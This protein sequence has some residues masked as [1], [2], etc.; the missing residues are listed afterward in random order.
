M[1]TAERQA[2]VGKDGQRPTLPGDGAR[3]G[4]SLLQVLKNTGVC[5][6]YQ[7]RHLRYLWVHNLPEPWTP[8]TVIGHSDDEIIPGHQAER[9]ISAKSRVLETGNSETL[10]FSLP[11]EAGM[12]W[13]DLWIDADKGATGE[14]DVVGVMTTVIETTDQKRREQTLKTLLRE[15]SHRSKNLLA[16]IQS[17]ATQTGRY[18]G[19]I[20]SFLSRFRGRL[21]SLASSQ[22]LI[23]SSNWRGADLRELVTSQVGRYSPGASRSI[24]FEGINPYLNPN[25]ALHIGLALHELVVNSV[26]Y[27]ALARNGGFVTVSAKPVNGDNGDVALSFS[28]TETVGPEARDMGEKKFGSV[29]LERVV[30]ASMNGTANFAIEGDTLE[31]RL[32]IPAGSF[33]I[34]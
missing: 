4:Q 32:E 23:T 21:Q 12:R 25:A 11:H 13:F 3:I 29:A 19:T 14:G 24:V 9:I 33:E 2:S 10:E 8:D 31:Y 7:D 34:E 20:D 22:D 28:W 18:S 5:V 26:S 16:I 17:I 1:S 27:G 15:L 6:L 30:P